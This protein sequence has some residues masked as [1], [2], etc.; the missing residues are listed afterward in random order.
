MMLLVSRLYL[1]NVNRNDIFE[2]I[3]SWLIIITKNVHNSQNKNIYINEHVHTYT[4]AI[5]KNV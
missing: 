1:L 2:F 5:K 4:D 3:I